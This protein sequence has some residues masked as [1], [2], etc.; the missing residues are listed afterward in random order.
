MK[1]LL[2]LILIILSGGLLI[3]F[4]T[5][6]EKN[7][8]R[9]KKAVSK[10]RNYAEDA[11]DKVEDNG[12]GEMGWSDLDWTNDEMLTKKASQL[13]KSQP[14]KDLKKYLSKIEKPVKKAMDQV[15]KDAK[16]T[17]KKIGKKIATLNIVS[18]LNERQD[19]ILSIL[20]NKRKLNM[21]EMASEFGDV[22]SRTLR[23]DM[24]KLEKQKIIRQVGKTRDSFYELIKF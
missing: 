14:V 11:I 21:M 1:K 4:L 24:E 15:S 3:F 16:K 2:T 19:K 23:R 17:E 8:K 20:K 10:A 5:D 22:T 13:V 9:L 12:F 6:P 18:G 7:T